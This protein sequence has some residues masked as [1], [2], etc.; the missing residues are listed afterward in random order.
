MR[1][2]IPGCGRGSSLGRVGALHP[3]PQG[4]AAS[5]GSVHRLRMGLRL[6]REDPDHS[7]H[8]F[9]PEWVPRLGGVGLS[10]NQAVPGTGFNPASCGD[11]G[12]EGGDDLL[13]HVGLGGQ[14]LGGD[15]SLLGSRGR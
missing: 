4:T 11:E 8:A 1:R 13:E 5:T 7:I 12:L 10:P 14:F 15:R 2:S 6:G 9:V 3:M